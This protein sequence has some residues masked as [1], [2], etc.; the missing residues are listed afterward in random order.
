[1]SYI[2][3]N[4]TD[5][6]TYNKSSMIRSSNMQRK[7]QSLGL[8]VLLPEPGSLLSARARAGV[9]TYRSCLLREK[10]AVRPRFAIQPIQ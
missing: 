7:L 6:S 4:K 8:G 1:M 10:H 9:G 2:A 5:I 3:S